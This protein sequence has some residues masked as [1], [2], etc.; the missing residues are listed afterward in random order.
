MSYWATRALI[1]GSPRADRAKKSR[2]SRVK[3]RLLQW[4]D[5]SL[6]CGADFPACTGRMLRTW[7]RGSTQ[8]HPRNR[9]TAAAVGE[10]CPNHLRHHRTGDE[11]APR[12]TPRASGEV[13]GRKPGTV[14][15]PAAR[16]ELRI[17]ALDQVPYV[18]NVEP[19]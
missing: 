5:I 17:L 16:V 8:F 6:C 15:I 19:D 3:S 18:V 9:V 12:H 13:D 2:R 10:E 4:R 14:I 1:S 7:L 11:Q